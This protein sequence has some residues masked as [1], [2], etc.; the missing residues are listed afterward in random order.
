[1]FS[2]KKDKWREMSK[3]IYG[4]IAENWRNFNYFWFKRRRDILN[5]FLVIYKH[6]TIPSKSLKN[7]GKLKTL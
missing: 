4:S 7:R 1:M 2:L 5:R 3:N 6:I